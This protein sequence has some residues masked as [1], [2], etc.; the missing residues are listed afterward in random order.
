MD[1]H[2]DPVV[3]TK[4]VP[5]CSRGG[6]CYHPNIATCRFCAPPLRSAP[7][8]PPSS[9]GARRFE[10]SFSA[11]GPEIMPQSSASPDSFETGFLR[12]SGNSGL[13]SG[14]DSGMHYAA[15]LR[16][17]GN[18]GSHSARHSGSLSA[19]N[20]GNFPPTLNDGAQGYT[21]SDLGNSLRR[22][23]RSLSV[24]S[25][26]GESSPTSSPGTFRKTMPFPDTRQ[27]RSLRTLESGTPGTLQHR[28]LFAEGGRRIS[29]WNDVPLHGRDLFLHCICTTP[30]GGFTRL[31]VAVDEPLTPLRVVKR[32]GRV[33][34][35]ASAAPFHIGLLPQTFADSEQEIMDE[36][37][38][39]TRP[40]L[41]YDN[42]PLEVLDVSSGHLHG[43]N[44][45][46]NVQANGIHP[47]QRKVGDV[48]LVRTLGALAL[49]DNRSE[50]LFWKMLVVD[51]CSEMAEDIKEI[52]DLA[53]GV[54]EE[55]KEWLQT[56]L[57]T[58]PGHQ[59][60]SI[61]W[62]A[63]SVAGAAQVLAE[64]HAAWQLYSDAANTPSPGTPSAGSLSR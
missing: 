20:S 34:N 36:K 12:S 57:C 61:F 48:F 51:A 40:E 54:L 14:S 46:S 31:Q 7:S 64:A 17:A 10:R 28:I 63:S 5:R 23:F 50:T 39:K 49:V 29:P 52:A 33:A 60:R 24:E 15:G 13:H 42:K 35:F 45:T 53:P 32:K 4:A 6:T 58:E 41:V 59:P 19:T 1:S 37:I 16:S 21:M 25:F 44:G 56:C 55:A 11:R 22:S 26:P 8:I 3:D 43:V 18:S 27:T 9:K 38:R 30:C 47:P 62:E 2:V